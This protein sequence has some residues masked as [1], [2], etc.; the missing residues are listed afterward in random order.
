VERPTEEPLL[1]FL[2]Q[3]YHDKAHDIRNWNRGDFVHGF[4]DATSALLHSVLFAPEFVEIAGCVFLRDFGGNKGEDL[5]AKI[6]EAKRTFI[7]ELQQLVW[8]HNCLEVGYVIGDP[9][10]SGHEQELLANLMADAWRLR[11]K[12][13]YPIG[14][15]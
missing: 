10:M 11:L 6:V 12:G 7:T 5:A 8:S 4:G 14:N 15:L 3:Q 9:R 2:R 1:T 13:K